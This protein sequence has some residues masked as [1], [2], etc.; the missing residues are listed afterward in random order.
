MTREQFISEFA[1]ILEISPGQLH[2]DTL[3]ASIATWDSVAYLSAMVFI[4]E[5]LGMTIKPDVLSQSESFG[6]ILRAVQGTLEAR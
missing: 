2:E 6:D 4:D 1:S 5:R 3:M